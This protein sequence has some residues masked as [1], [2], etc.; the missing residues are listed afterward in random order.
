ML[1]LGSVKSIITDSVKNG[2]IHFDMHGFLTNVVLADLNLSGLW[3]PASLGIAAGCQTLG[4]SDESV[5]LMCAWDI[6][7][8]SC[9]PCSCEKNKSCEF[10]HAPSSSVSPL[11][12]GLCFQLD[13]I[14]G[15]MHEPVGLGE[16]GGK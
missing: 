5:R 11:S 10:P 4:V 14:V 9:A 16:L 8:C 12:V 3:D 1:A 2:R 15:W 7:K 13:L 6:G